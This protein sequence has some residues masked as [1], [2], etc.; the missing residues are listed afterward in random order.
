METQTIPGS[1][2][3]VAEQV[4]AALRAASAAP[5]PYNSQP[6]RFRLCP[7]RI[8]LHADPG[9]RL[10]ATDPQDQELRLACGAALLNLRLVLE[11][12]HIRPLVTLIPDPGRPDLLAVVRYGGRIRPTA[13]TAQLVGVIPLRRTNRRPFLDQSVP[14]R[15]VTALAKAAE[16]ERCWLHPVEEPWQRAALRQLVLRAHRVQ[17]ADPAFLAEFAEQTRRGISP[18]VA[19]PRPEPQDVWTLRDFAGGQG[20]IRVPGKDFEDRPLIVVL[21]SFYDGP[22]A[23]L[24]AGQALQRVLLTATTVGLSGSFLSQ[25]VEV[26]AVREDLRRLLGGGLTPQAVLRLGYGL[27]VPRSPRRP[28]HELLI[29]TSPGGHDD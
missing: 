14:R 13:A 21:S 7:D 17:Q 25:P 22:G 15:F 12:M 27:P 24:S 2:G 10:P 19:G 29:T 20:T 16:S 26:P 4:E 3:L 5:S 23:D 8:E 6:W 11:S 1:M 9:R 28:L 18:A